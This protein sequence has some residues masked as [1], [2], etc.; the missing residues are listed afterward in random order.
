M[1][2]AERAATARVVPVHT[3]VPGR[4]RLQVP[5]LHRC[6]RLEEV[7]ERTLAADP[8]VRHVAANARTGN[9]LVL[10]AAERSPDMLVAA[11]ERILGTPEGTAAAPGAST[12]PDRPWHR[13]S[14]AAVVRAVDGASPDGLSAAEARHRLA[15]FGPNALSRPRGRS[16]L[17]MLAEQVFSLP[18][19]LLGMSAAISL[20]TGGLLEAVAILGVVAANA[21]IGFVTEDRAERTLQ[22]LAG[23]G[24]PRA[25]VVRDRAERSIPA[26][27]VVVGD[28]LVLGGGDVVAADARLLETNGLSVDE[29]AL[30]GESVAVAKH[31][32]AIVGEIV[33]L[34]DRRNMVYRGTSV[35]GGTGLAVVVA[36]GCNTEVGRIQTLVGTTRAPE[37]RMQHQLARVGRQLVWLSGGICGLVFVVGLLRGQALLPMLRTA[38]SLAVAAVPEGLPT[39]ATTTLALGIAAMRR[40]RVMVRRLSAVETL[41][42]VQVI[43]FDKTGTLT[44]NRMSVVAVATSTCRYQVRGERFRDAAGHE[45]EGDERAQVYRLLQLGALCNEAEYRTSDAGGTRIVGSATE[46]ALIQAAE[47]AGLDVRRLRNRH[48]N[49]ETNHRTERARYMVTIHRMD[50]GPPLVAVKGS[51]DRVLGLCHWHVADGRRRPLTDADRMRIDSLNQEMAGDALRVLG[52]A[53]GYGDDAEAAIRSGLTWIGLVGMADPTRHGMKALMRVFHQAGIRTVMITG[54]QGATAYAIARELDLSGGLP[55]EILESSHLERLS[56]DML[57]ALA[58]R[59][60]VFARVSPAHKLEIVRA[61]QRGGQVVAMTGDGVNDSPALKAADIG[62]AMGHGGSDV[63]REV[64]DVVLEDDDLRTLALAVARGR[65]THANIRKAIRFLIATNMSEILVTLVGTAAGAGSLLSPMQLL[66]INLVSDVAPAVAL[67][68][69]PP[70]PD[71][72][73]LP[74]RDPAEPVL[75]P[76]DFRRLAL[77]AGTLGAGALLGGAYGVLRYGPGPQACTLTA[78]SLITGQLLHALSCRSDRSRLWPRNHL[79]RNPVLSSAV[80]GSLA[81]QAVALAWPPLR[82]LL[83]LAPLGPVDGLAAAAAGMVPLLLNEARKPGRPPAQPPRSGA[84]TLTAIEA[85][86]WRPLPAQAAD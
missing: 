34:G 78:A 55:I 69:E 4:A 49:R 80:A 66:W 15:R 6:P 19:A 25:R 58:Q 52:V 60:H 16:R 30:T 65:T 57:S 48:P 82:G 31:S 10:Y 26:E 32:H 45:A 84:G 44:L 20:A 22:G 35:T 72:L 23:I 68:M 3:V 41:G 59:A 53:Y 54:D 75:R 11:V 21:G 17:A 46:C 81:L 64:A 50:A 71:V 36:T 37:T 29:S 38:V 83:N 63:A 77:E 86:D 9:V 43:C 73:T 56:P 5:G 51:P 47:A 70:E 7:L 74:P 13:Q 27:Q 24:M 12:G 67:A 2:H 40:H 85:P 1:A 61:L 18:V 14:A 28:L 62:I 8:M 39:T 76:Q 42:A 79:P 33:P